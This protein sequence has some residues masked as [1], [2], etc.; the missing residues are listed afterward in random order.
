MIKINTHMGLRGEFKAILYNSD[1]SIAQETPWS[2][3][4]ITDNGLDIYDKG[5]PSAWYLYCSIGSGS[6]PPSVSDTT[7]ETHLATSSVDSNPLPY[8]D[9]PRPPVAPDWERWSMRKWRFTNGLGTGTV[10]EFTIGYANNGTDIFCRHVLPTPIVKN[11]NQ[12]L[13]IFYKF[14]IYITSTPTTGSFL[15]DGVNYDW[16]S[17]PINRDAYNYSLFSRVGLLTSYTPRFYP[18]TSASGTDTTEPTSTGSVSH[19]SPEFGSS[20]TATGNYWKEL[21]QTFG[22]NQANTSDRTIR[23]I[24]HRNTTYHYF[25]TGIVATDGPNVGLGFPKDETEILTLVTRISWGRYTP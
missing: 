14:Y 15:F 1:G 22:L 2:S 4:L 16:E 20:Y 23:W 21:T 13:D 8:G 17:K 24:T 10:R 19:S 9:Y 12:T 3:N 25:Q 11:D 7:I 5:T 18:S 6:T